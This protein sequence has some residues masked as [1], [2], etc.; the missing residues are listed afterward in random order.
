MGHWARVTAHPRATW[1]AMLRN[2]SRVFGWTSARIYDPECTSRQHGHCG[3][4]ADNDSAYHHRPLTNKEPEY[5]RSLC[6]A[7]PLSAET[8]IWLPNRRWW[9]E[10]N[11]RTS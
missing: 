7:S 2:G 6:L 9:S 1:P 4:G 11:R 8:V 5:V 10:F 3:A